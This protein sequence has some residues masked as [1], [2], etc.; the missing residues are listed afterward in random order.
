LHRI[1]LNNFKYYDIHYIFVTTSNQD[2]R[3]S[4]ILHVMDE[5]EKSP[6][7][8]NQYF[9]EKDLPF[10]RVQYYLYK[11]AIKERGTEGLYDLRS[12]GNNL[13]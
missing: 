9:K 4:T 1:K 6:L 3:V 2:T 8:V 7:S 5:I 11:N 13:K 12:K 10:G